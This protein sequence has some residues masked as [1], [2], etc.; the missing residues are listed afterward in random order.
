MKKILFIFII[1]SLSL[2]FASEIT[3]SLKFSEPQMRF[4]KRGITLI[5]EDGVY[6]T[7]PGNP[8]L[9][10]KSVKKLLNPGEK[11]V[12]VSVNVIS[13][14]TVPLENDLNWYQTPVPVSQ[15]ENVKPT[16]KNAEVYEKNEIYPQKIAQDLLTYYYRGYA[17][18][19]V[20]IYPYQYNP[21]TKELTVVSEA[22]VTIV[23]EESDEAYNALRFIRSDE[24]TLK[25]LRETVDNPSVIGHYPINARDGE[26]DNILV[27]ISDQQ[28]FEN[29]E[30]LFDLK[31]KQGFNP[32]LKDVNE[33][34][35][36]VDGVDNQDK[37]RNFIID[38][39]LNLG[40][41][42]VLLAGDTEIIPHRGFYCYI[43]GGL[44]AS[45]TDDDIPSDLYY[46][47]LDRVGNG[48]GP[49]W[50]TDNDNYFGEYSGWGGNVHTE[51]DFMPEIGVARIC[52]D[53]EEEF[54]HAVNKQVMY[55]T[56]PVIGDV[57]EALL[58]GE[59]MNEDY[60]TYGGDCMDEIETG[61]TFN[62]YTTAGIGD[63]FNISKLYDRDMNWN[64]NTVKNAMNGGIH[65]ISHLGH[66]FNFWNM[67]IHL[68]EVTDENF[69]SNGINH[70]FHI[71]YSQ[72]CYPAAFDNRGVVNDYYDED[73]IMEAF[74]TNQNGVAA[75]VGNSRYGWYNFFNTNSSSQYLNRQF[76]DAVFGENITHISLANDDSK[77][78][79]I[80]QVNDPWFRWV[81]YD[82]NVFGDP[83]LDIFTAQPTEMNPDYMTSLHVSATSLNIDNVENGARLCFSKDGNVIASGIAGETGSI[84]LVFNQALEETGNYDLYIT[85]HNRIIYTGIVEVINPDVP[86]LIIDNLSFD[87][88]DGDN[89]IESG[90]TVTADITIRNAGQQMS[91]AVSLFIAD[92]NENIVIIDS[93][94][95]SENGIGAGESV[96]FED[97]VSFTVNNDIED[98]TEVEIASVITS[99]SQS[100]D[101]SLE[102]TLNAPVVRIQSIE[103]ADGGNNVLE[104]GETASVN[105]T[106]A[107]EGHADLTEL[108]ASLMSENENITINNASA[109]IEGLEPESNASITF[110]VIVAENVPPGEIAEFNL[111]IEGSGGYTA[112]LSFSL[113]IG[114]ITE[115][116]E[117]GDFSSFDW[118][119]SGN[120]NWTVGSYAYEGSYAVRSGN[121]GHGESS[122]LFITGNVLIAGE[123]SF[124]IKPN[125][126]GYSGGMCFFL[127]DGEEKNSWNVNSGWEEYSYPVTAGDHTF[128]WRYTEYSEGMDNVWIDKI[129]FPQISF[130]N[131][132]SPSSLIPENN[133]VNLPRNQIISWQNGTETEF[134]D[135]YLD[136]VNPPVSKVLDKVA[137]QESF[138]AELEWGKKY[139]WKVVNYSPVNDTE[140]VKSSPVQIFETALPP[141]LIQVGSGNSTNQNLPMNPFYGYSYSQSIYL[142]SEI[143]CD[144]A[145]IGKIYYHYNGAHEF[146]DEI[147]VYMG[148]TDKTVFSSSSDWVPVSSMT[149]VYSGNYN[150][151]ASDD[152]Q[153]IELDSPFV[154]NNTDNLV[155]AFDENT[156]GYH[157]SDDKFYCSYVTGNRSLIYKSDY[158]NPDPNNSGDY[159]GS[160]KNFIPNIR[161]KLANNSPTIDFGDLN[162]AFNENTGMTNLF[163]RQKTPNTLPL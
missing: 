41:E 120:V 101:A 151:S 127:I 59:L 116:F 148:H 44:D 1:I 25:K 125:S 87:T 94:Y 43:N 81:Y 61:G 142:Q 49:D 2:L 66:S 15:R 88:S 18:A 104:S 132:N 78:D 124:Y 83:T 32:L 58:V 56:E 37:I 161:F 42:F 3:T 5:D 143:N 55:Q 117:T 9:P 109:E 118:T 36:D 74:T 63:D 17:I 129:V 141:N 8:V 86:Y 131:L 22:E 50:N 159:P 145:V 21:V 54:D 77:T 28:Y 34:Y 146:G 68:S 147:T 10:A 67:K 19:N 27:I 139:Y 46:S 111:D 70:G 31:L 138:S 40:T 92:S 90:E 79:G 39:Y 126:H 23:T 134:V 57:T 52:A 76:F 64:M 75:Y 135:L 14:K 119:H 89:V 130:E 38:C 136:T 13:Q 133:T 16:L 33:I 71:V 96:V 6:I 102:F 163:L 24:K 29:L 91:E 107:N 53:T 69:T 108:T 123:I 113:S 155:V 98:Q 62:E 97:A 73:C 65:L 122:S 157:S 112:D 115:D 4:D 128:E 160:L 99:G 105:I 162:V 153:V 114:F 80:A 85:A 149:Q 82:V 11:A 12:S 26:N 45:W 152:W 106:L 110:N 154:Y 47:A 7:K 144:S 100:W 140:C 103:V 72:G 48:I 156:D 121:V 20:N 150:L 158:A 35:S 137:P 93:S 51:A 84:N 30:P 95:V 60:Q